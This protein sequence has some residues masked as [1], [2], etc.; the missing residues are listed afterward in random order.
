M[1]V[2][3]VDDEPLA[4]A[5]LERMIGELEGY[6]VSADAAGAEQAMKAIAEVDPDIVLLDIHMP[7]DDGLTLARRLG[8]MDDPPAVIFCTAFDEHALDAFGTTAV[9]YLLKPVRKEQLAAALEKAGRVNKIQRSATHAGPARSSITAKTHR[10]FERIPVENIRFF[11]A[12]QKY[13][14]VYHTGGQHL[15]DNTLKELEEEFGEQMVRVHRNALVAV[16]HIEA[17]ERCA[18]GGY[19]VRLAGIADTPMVS[20]RHASAVKALLQRL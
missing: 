2:L 13:V 5:R 8:E 12:D 10:G 9:G 3:I 19:R 6:R 17:L 11:L 1:E 16:R 18:E 20:R 7:G 14:T 15:L 4:R